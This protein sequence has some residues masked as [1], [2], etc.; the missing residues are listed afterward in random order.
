MTIGA[1]LKH[2]GVAL[3]GQSAG[4]VVTAEGHHGE[5]SHRRDVVSGLVNHAAAQMYLAPAEERSEDH[6]KHEGER[7]GE[8]R[9]K[10]GCARTPW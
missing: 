6:Q 8:E 2:T 4:D 9:L 7:E 10:P 3:E 5:S 1:A